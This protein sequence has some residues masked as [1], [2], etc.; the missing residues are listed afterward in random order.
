MMF[1]FEF[2]PGDSQSQ[3]QGEVWGWWKANSGVVLSYLLTVGWDS[4][5]LAAVLLAPQQVLNYPV[6]LSG[7]MNAVAVGNRHWACLFSAW[8]HS[9]G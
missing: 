8:A 2:K 3:S 4:L 5:S 9:C 1:Y 7:A 6:W